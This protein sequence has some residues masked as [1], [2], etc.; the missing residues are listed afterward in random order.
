MAQENFADKLL[1]AHHQHMP[2]PHYSKVSP[3]ADEPQAYRIQRDYVTLRQKHDP[4]AGYKAG[5]TSTAGQAKFNV[6]QAL[7]GVLFSSG[8]VN[9]PAAIRLADAGKL[10]L[11]TEIG[12]V[13]AQPITN[14]IEELTDL[15]QAI[16]SVVP[17]IELPDLNYAMPKSLSGVDLIAAN[18][19]SHQFLL[20]NKQ[21]LAEVGDINQIS[22]SLS[23]NQKL[24]FSGKATDALGDQWQ[25][26]KWLVNQLV[27]Q[28]YQLSAGDLLITGALGKM[29]PA[30]AGDYQADFGTLGPVN[31]SVSQ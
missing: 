24:L 21:P 6:T 22:T 29:I 20:G 1:Q 16:E 27:S 3:S 2:M 8:H 4:V 12:F 28:G 25:A 11:E 14:P 17:V 18:V 13:L 10:M 9:D 30:Q 31:F 19:A 26:L 23:F 15:K 5:L 7:S